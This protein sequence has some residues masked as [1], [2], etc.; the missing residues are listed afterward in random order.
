MAH[1]DIFRD[2]LATKYSANGH[3]L[4][5]PR[6][7]KGHGRVE[8]GDVGFIREGQFHRLFNALLSADHPSHK[9][10]GVPEDHEHLIPSMPDH[11][12]SSVLGRNNYYSFGVTMDTE[13]DYRA[14][15]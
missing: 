10:L 8:I 12:N 4:W 5:E 2:Q 6:P 7:R 14:S 11:I 13:L 1:Y 9:K 3:A 15:R